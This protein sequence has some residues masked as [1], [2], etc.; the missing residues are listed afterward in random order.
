MAKNLKTIS[1]DLGPKSYDI[2]IG[3]GALGALA[4]AVKPYSK[5]IIITDANLA[6]L[7]LPKL[8]ATLKEFNV[9]TI[10]CDA[11]EQTK[12]F[13]TLEKIC[14]STLAKNIDRHSLIIAFGGGV[15]GDVAGFAASIL[16]RGIDFIQIPTTLLSAVDS[17]VGGKTAINSAH[18]KNLIGSFYQPKLVVCDLDLLTTLP[19]RELKAGYAEVVKYGLIMDSEFFD[20]LKQNSSRTYQEPQ[21]LAQ[22]IAKSCELKAKIVAQDETERKNIR[23]LLNFGH[24]FAH[25]F[26]TEAG[27]S[28]E[29]LHGEAVSIGMV[30]AAHMSVK[31]GMLSAA[32][33][34]EIKTYLSAAGLFTDPKQIRKNWNKDQLA[35]HIF[36]DKKNEHQQL[37]FIL[38]ESIGSAMVKK[39]VPYSLF[40]EVL[41]EFV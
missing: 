6:K 17:A 36:K 3:D 26:E 11:G 18:G 32:E 23:A 20:F 38:L 5:I 13:A 39:S 10:I 40:L 4:A 41:E 16:L 19:I 31:L 12:S 2:I 14:E 7:H 33:Y 25:I 28:D 8:Q 27:Y 35:A 34:S 29:L 30:M 24:S 1:L 15:I 9:E 37:T 21:L 22:I